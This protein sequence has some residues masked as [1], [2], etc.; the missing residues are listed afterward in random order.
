MLHGRKSVSNI[1][2]AATVVYVTLQCGGGWREGWRRV[3][4]GLEGS[5]GGLERGVEDSEG[6]VEKTQVNLVCRGGYGEDLVGPFLCF[7]F[8]SP[9]F[10]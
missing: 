6:G 8:R 3:E 10:F 7:K 9:Q 4:R 2:A 1:G 5:G